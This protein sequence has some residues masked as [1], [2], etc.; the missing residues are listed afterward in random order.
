MPVKPSQCEVLDQ[1]AIS[2]ACNSN[3]ELQKAEVFIDR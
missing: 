3:V 2:V 1:L